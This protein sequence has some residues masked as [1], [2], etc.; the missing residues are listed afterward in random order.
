MTTVAV[1]V[2]GAAAS[3]GLFGLFVHW[4]RTGKEHCP[5]VFIL[6]VVLVDLFLYENQDLAPRGLFHP[7]TGSLDWRLPEVLIVV[8]L[9]ARLAVRGWPRAMGV[10]AL[11]WAAFAAWFAVAA[12]EGILRHN[13]MVKLPYE[14]KAIVYVV[15]G[16]AL[17]A[18]VPVSRYFEARVFERV[19]RWSSAAAC[20]L[21]V[22]TLANQ[23]KDVNLPLLPLPD[24]GIIGGDTGGVFVAVGTIG[25]LLELAKDR[26]D[27]LTLMATAPLLLSPFFTNQRA[28]LL[29]LGAAVTTIVVA[30][31]SR[32][33]R[34]RLHVKGAQVALCAAAVVGVVLAV[35]VIPALVS[36][37]QV[38]LPLATRTL[39]A[40]QSPGKIESAEARASKWTVAWNDAKQELV[41]GQ[42][43]GYEYSYYEPGPDQ[44]YVVDITENTFLDL[45]LWT[46]LVGLALFVAAVAVSVAD[47]LATWRRHPDPAVG[48]LALALVAVVVGFVVKGQVESLLEK[49]RE[50]TVLGLTLGMLR[51]AATSAGG[52]RRSEALAP[53]EEPV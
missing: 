29:M 7:G 40:F 46:G 4:E 1:L 48:V 19:V 23:V 3:A 20:V 38:E 33:A 17:A 21:I 16:Y 31:L 12:V 25:L 8:A 42:G 30:A 28:S 9:L 44:S 14:A 27:R 45:L 51:S 52:L 35:S 24:F 22:M 11:L 47:G 53:V 34:M 18:G 15:G 13:S 5:V 2:V 50:A 49:Y 32:T 37:R 39:S 41:L 36:Q 10:A 43:L 26:P 6:A